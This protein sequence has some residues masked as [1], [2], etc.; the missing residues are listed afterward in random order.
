[1]SD[2]ISRKEIIDRLERV[3]QNG[4]PS[5]DGMHP[6]SAETVLE[7]VKELSEHGTNLAEVGTDCISRQAAIEA[8]RDWEMCYDWDEHCREEPKEPWV[9]SPS[10]VVNKL[11]PIQ[12][13]RGK[14]ENGRPWI[15]KENAVEA[16]EMVEPS[17][18]A[19]PKRGKWIKT[20]RWG[21]VYY[22]NQCRNYLDFDGVNAGRGS[23]NFCPNCG[24]DMRGEQD[25]SV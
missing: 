10:D 2:L 13:K 23:T 18:S 17:S 6:I 16:I 7:V 24:A 14:D 3:I 15:Y 12:P 4:V 1:M 5:E 8:L 21:R 25:D 11:P 9:V 19:E 22:C 20:A